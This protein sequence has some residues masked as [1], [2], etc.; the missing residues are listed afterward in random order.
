MEWTINHKL[1]SISI[2]VLITYTAHSPHTPS[3][4]DNLLI[5]IFFDPVHDEMNLFIFIVTKSY[6]SIFM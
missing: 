5:D 1:L 4:Q 3:P 2:K 6:D